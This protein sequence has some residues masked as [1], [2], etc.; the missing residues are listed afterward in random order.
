MRR[1]KFTPPSM[2]KYVVLGGLTVAGC[3]VSEP[4][5]S[6]R[7][8]GS[9]VLPTEPVRSREDGP[10]A[11]AGT[12]AS[13]DCDEA[14]ANSDGTPKRAAAGPASRPPETLVLAYGD[15]GPQASAFELLGFEWW[16]WEGG[17]SWEMCDSF[18]I[19]VVVFKGAPLGVVKERYP[20][21]I[22]KADLTE[23]GLADYRYVEHKAA[24][25]HIDRELAEIAGAQ[26]LA[27]MAETLRATRR[28]IVEG[29]GE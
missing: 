1:S 12:S 28:R 4:V 9:V 20:S 29:L 27:Q 10:A 25:A 23:R 14:R 17:G 24:L 22:S 19:R 26:E 3:A 18:D 15:F 21:A 7:G 13:R 5:A 8:A 16:G 2:V 11:A 6:S